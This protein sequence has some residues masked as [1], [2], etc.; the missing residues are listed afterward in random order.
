MTDL[1]CH[2]HSSLPLQRFLK[3][4]VISS[5]LIGVL[6]VP[7]LSLAQFK[8]GMAPTNSSQQP[9]AQ[10]LDNRAIDGA[11][12]KTTAD[13]IVAVIN[14]EVIT[15]TDVDRRIARI[16]AQSQGQALPPIDQ[17]KQQVLDLLIDEKVQVAQAKVLGMDVSDAEVD[18]TVE[19]IAAQN[20]LTVAQLRKRMQSEGLDFTRYRNSLRE[21]LLLQRVR[22]REVNARIRLTD[23]EIESVISKGLT[24][25]GDTRLNLAHV[26]V[27]VP[28]AASMTEVA[29]LQAKARSIQSEAS[30]GANFAELARKYSDDFTTAKSGGAFGLRPTNKL[31][32]LFVN[33]ASTLQ[34]GEIAPVV[35]SGAG[36]H[37]IKLLEREAPSGL[38]YTQQR[39]RHILLRVNAQ[40]D[41]RSVMSKMLDIQKQIKTGQASF[42][43]LA[44]QYSE[45][46][47]AVRGGDLGWAS[48]GQYV[49]E[50]EKALNALQTGEVSEPVISR[51]GIHL[52]QLVERK[53]VELTSEQKKEAARN[54][55]RE[56]RFESTYADWARELRAS[57]WVEVRDAP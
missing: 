41:P 46:G 56:Q 10:E 7:S 55:L 38:S 21:Q 20:K 34:V 32:D 27:R 51:F 3:Q 13:Y 17:L 15:R 57:T 43:Q 37:I 50:F 6:L 16:T 2:T 52:I 47:S 29:V 49:P 19:G 42:E 11:T 24:T 30:S 9:S 1:F 4:A 23:D 28:E 26:F 45:D 25:G 8:P 44:R 48:P 40:Q 53:E 36:F 54:L 31:P 5:L 14:Q 22:E 35:R 18:S 33:A 39:A 12:R